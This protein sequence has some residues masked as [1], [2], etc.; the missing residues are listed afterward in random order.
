MSTTELETMKRRVREMEEEATKLREMQ[1]QVERELTA[2]TTG[3]SGGS[4]AA[5]ASGEPA[6]V[7][8]ARSVYVGNV[9]YGATPEELQ[10]HFQACGAI[11]RITILCDKWTGNPK[12]FAYIEFAEPAAVQ[13]ALTLHESNFRGRVLK[14]MA[15]RGNIPG[16]NWRGGVGRGAPGRGMRGRG[17]RGGRSRRAAF[18]PY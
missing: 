6:E 18:M 11:N 2:A 9:D 3:H 10:S 1:A 7:V 17:P 14:V 13:N 4:G 8:D 5:D 12:G 16:Y 15:K